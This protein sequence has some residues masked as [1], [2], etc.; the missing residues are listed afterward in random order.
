MLGYCIL[1][2]G[3]EVIAKV[4]T[5]FQGPNCFLVLEL[6]TA[7]WADTCEDVTEEEYSRLV[8]SESLYDF[9]LGNFI[10]V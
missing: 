3:R 6:E 9:I 5:E 4:E 8:E 2:T 10:G 1:P 7:I